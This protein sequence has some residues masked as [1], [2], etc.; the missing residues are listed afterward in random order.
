MT[1]N[2]RGVSSLTLFIAII[3][4]LAFITFIYF[5]QKSLFPSAYMIGV[6]DLV[7]KITFKKEWDRIFRTIA[8]F[9]VK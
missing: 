5:Y 3:L 8:N 4:L 6:D 9:K 7:D 2:K 1:L